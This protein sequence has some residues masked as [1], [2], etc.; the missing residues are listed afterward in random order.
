MS[1]STP[2]GKVSARLGEGASFR[3]RSMGEKLVKGPALIGQEKAHLWEVIL[4]V[5]PPSKLRA[6]RVEV[7]LDGRRKADTNHP[8]E[9]ESR[10]T[11]GQQV[12]EDERNIMNYQENANQTHMRYY[13]LHRR[14]AVTKNTR[15]N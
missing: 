13:L 15:D 2:E 11:D 1:V 8:Q 12:H 4:I 6:I 14:M 5:K 7:R 3:E 10:Q 9:S